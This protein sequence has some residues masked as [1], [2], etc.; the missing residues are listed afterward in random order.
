MSLDEFIQVRKDQG[1]Y[2]YVC[3]NNA[4]YEV[5]LVGC[6]PEIKVHI[7]KACLK[8]IFSKALKVDEAQKSKGE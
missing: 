2:C 1:H 7:C 4:N 5:E 6:V 3:D 8:T